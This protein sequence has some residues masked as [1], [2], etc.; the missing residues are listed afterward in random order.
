MLD[1]LAALRLSDCEPGGPGGR[2]QG[3]AWWVCVLRSWEGSKE[4]SERQPL[5]SRSWGITLD[6]RDPVSS[7]ITLPAQVNHARFIFITRTNCGSVFCIDFDFRFRVMSILYIAWETCH[8]FLCSEDSL[9]LDVSFSRV[10]TNL[11]IKPPGLSAFGGEVIFQRF[12]LFVGISSV[13]WNH[14]DN[15]NVLGGLV[16]VSIEYV[17]AF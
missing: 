4:G 12:L 15:L 16:F 7:K 1:V 5:P 10:W 3:A 8:N 11:P 9:C 17:L 6:Y 13:L 2:R 14:F